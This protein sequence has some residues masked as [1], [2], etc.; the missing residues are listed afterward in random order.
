LA[1][2]AAERRLGKFMEPA[3]WTMLALRDGPQPLTGVF[4]RARSLDGPIGH[5]TLLA[6]LVRLER[7]GLVART[8][9]RDRGPAYALTPLG[10]AAAGTSRAL[11]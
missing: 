8:T 11:S 2:V 9:D 3:M 10:S 6:A 4:D 5:G 7:L 1:E